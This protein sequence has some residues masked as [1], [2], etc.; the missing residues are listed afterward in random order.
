[1]GR[2]IK[3]RD[4]AIWHDRMG[5]TADEIASEYELELS[6]IFAALTYYFDNREQIDRSIRES[7]TLVLEL[8]DRDPSE[9]QKKLNEL[10]GG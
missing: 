1:L 7:G 4:I 10:R 5:M 9:F 3:V 2:R 8:R 6:Q